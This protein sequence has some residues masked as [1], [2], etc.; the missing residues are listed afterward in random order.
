[1]WRGDMEDMLLMGLFTGQESLAVTAPSG[2]FTEQWIPA[3]LKCPSLSQKGSP[4]IFENRLDN[5]D[6]SYK[7]IEG[8]T[9]AC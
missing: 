1:M 3:T 2:T 6:A 7:R 5:S 8:Q 4:Y 9:W